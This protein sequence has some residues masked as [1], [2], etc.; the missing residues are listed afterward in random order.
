MAQRSPLQD[1]SD[2]DDIGYPVPYVGNS[3]DRAYIRGFV[4]LEWGQILR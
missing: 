3:T 2:H 1:R 4:R